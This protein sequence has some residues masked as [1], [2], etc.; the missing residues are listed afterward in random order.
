MANETRNRLALMKKV[1]G[2]AF[3]TDAYLDIM[4]LKN[5][6]WHQQ[7]SEGGSAIGLGLAQPAYRG[8][9]GAHDCC[10]AGLVSMVTN[11]ANMPRKEI[12][13]LA[14]EN[15]LPLTKAF[16]YAE[17]GF[18]I[19]P[20]VVRVPELPRSQQQFLA[21]G[22]TTDDKTSEKHIKCGIGQMQAAIDQVNHPGV[23]II[24]LDL[25]RVIRTA[26]MMA[27]KADVAFPA[28]LCPDPDDPAAWQAW[29]D[30]IDEFLAVAGVRKKRKTRVKLTA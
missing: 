26:Y 28:R 21:I 30:E 29:L 23:A 20:G 1:Q 25:Q 13:R 19:E 9:F 11:Y 7:V 24:M 14:C 17:R 8:I 22:V 3:G 16:A 5:S 27:E 2:P 18:F 6:T 10:M 12:A 15:W 4:N